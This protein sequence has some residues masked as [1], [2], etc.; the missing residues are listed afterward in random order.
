MGV[1]HEL[2]VRVNRTIWIGIIGGLLLIAA[3]LLNWLDASDQGAQAPVVDQ[4]TAAEETIPEAIPD[5][6]TDDATDDA[7]NDATDDAS[8]PPP[9]ASSET[10]S[11]AQTTEPTDEDA[12]EAVPSDAPPP[13]PPTFDVVRIDPNGD[14]V[15]AGR[16]APGAKVAVLDGSE[17]LGIADADPRGEWVYLPTAPLAP[18]PHELTLR[19]EL[20]DGRI[21]LG[22]GTVVLVVPD[23]GKDVAGRETDDEGERQP[24][25]LLVPDAEQ[26]GVEVLQAPTT[27]PDTSSAPETMAATTTA[28][29]EGVRSEDG[30]LSVETIDYDADGNLSIAGAGPDGAVVMAYL[31]NELLGFTAVRGPDSSWRLN[32][33]K[34]VVPGVYTLRL[35]ALRD[36][37]VIARLEIPFS[38]AAPFEDLDGDAFIIVQPGNSLWRIARRTMGSGVGFTVIYQANA[39]QIRDPDLIYPGQVFEIPRE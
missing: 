9:Q 6:A 12:A 26:P 7:T 24:M 14:T 30:T 29:P 35:D 4:D 38:R 39:D 27:E 32:P 1:S 33:L 23:A 3:L 13:V 20:P 5:S 37:A 19:S 18:G 17:T 15:M 21:V 16:A 25:V 11:E 36:N 28:E 22:T 2:G 34:E 31:D 8:P 10:D